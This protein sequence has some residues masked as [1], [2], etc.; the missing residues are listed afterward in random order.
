VAGLTFVNQVGA[1]EG[2]NQ[3]APGTL[4]PES[5]VRWSQDV[6][7]DRAGLMRRRGPFNK[8]KMLNNDTT[9]N[10]DGL[11]TYAIS[12]V[13]DERVLSVLSTYDPTGDERIGMLVDSYNKTS[14]TRETL[15]RVFDKTFRFLGYEK[16]PFVV[17]PLS[18]VSHKPA[19]GGGLWVSIC[20]DPSDADTHYQ[21]F[22]RGGYSSTR[23]GAGTFS[24]VTGTFT[25]E[26]VTNLSVE[27]KGL[28]DDITISSTTNVSKG[29]FVYATTSSND[30]Y[31]GTIKEINASIIT[32]DKRPFL[33]D[34]NTDNNHSV[35][36][37][38]A[39]ATS[40]T[41]VVTVTLSS[42]VVF[43]VGDV[44]YLTSASN[45]NYNNLT[46]T[47]TAVPP[48]TATNTF[49]F[50]T[51]FNRGTASDITVHM[52]N[53]LI[54][55]DRTDIP[56]K[57]VSV[58]PYVHVHGRGLLTINDG[59]TTDVISGDAGS[60]AE[61]HWQAASVKDYNV[62][63][64]SDNLYLGKVKTITN[65]NTLD[66][67]S[68]S[69]IKL[70]GEEYVMRSTDPTN[71]ITDYCVGSSD[72]NIMNFAGLYTA[73]YAGYQWYGN[74]GQDD[75]NTNRVVFSAPHDRE[76]VD[77]SR[78]AADSIIFP[79][80]SSFRG[81]GSS[82]AGLLV[83]LEDRT[84]IL[85]GNDRTNFSVEQ[86]VPEGCLCASSIVEYGGGVFWAGK[87]GIMF[88]DG[89]SVRNLTKDNLGLY[90]TDSL[91]V[92]NP[93]QDRVLGFMHKNN[94]IMH[95]TSWNSPFDPVR[96]EPIYADA[97][98]TT[99]GLK[100][101]DGNKRP[102][103]EF[104]PDFDYDDFF[105][106][107]NTPIF[108]DRKIL[109]NPEESST[110]GVGFTWQGA[111]TTYTV[112]N[113][114]LTSNVATLTIAAHPFLVNDKIWVSG[115]DSTFN[116]Q[117]TVTGITSTTVSY[118]KVASNVISQAATGTISK[119]RITWE[120]TI[121]PY[122]WG[123]LRSYTSLTFAIY[124]PTNAL[125]TLSNLDLRGVTNIE[126]LYGLK[127]IVGVNSVENISGTNRLRARLIDIHPVF[128]TNTNGEDDLL[129]EKINIPDTDIVKGPD[130]YLQTKHFTVGDPI[131]RK[132]FQRIML[133][134]L[135]Y[136]GAIRMDLV[137]D[138]DNDSV[139]INKK[140]HKYWEIFTEKG[141]DWTYLTDIQLPKLVSPN[142]ASWENVE[143]TV[144]YWDELFTADFNRYSK[145]I[146]WRKASVGFRLYQ[147]NNYK[148]PYNGVVTR[149]YRVEMQGFSI[150]FKP[151]RQ[152]RI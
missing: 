87:S 49:T 33:W 89:S 85:R 31:I 1:V 116:G 152:G 122:K 13:T 66:L 136:D 148:K 63:R 134:M 117:Y 41:S 123:P 73:I 11:F 119:S 151:L 118:A 68:D 142:R 38:N 106:E 71:L 93:S 30:Y 27:H 10:T 24:S 98:D 25:N 53:D 14:N 139:D 96:Y 23:T 150:G 44:V 79:G 32:L 22:W 15:L 91:D 111:P 57:F 7:F 88:F 97:W 40:S 77:L 58:R 135:L 9:T 50:S 16:L 59:D 84:Y 109:N 146:S 127:T 103:D 141:Y 110:T 115:V 121:N 102:W 128:D 19:L 62:Y 140:K 8:F 45:A 112:T 99:D 18:I 46:A 54:H 113:K 144:T 81:L 47:I 74:F 65:N 51:T 120:A 82:S 29:Q 5:F 137:D 80:K 75:E 37:T 83:F 39:A 101:A 48:T 17:T 94:L 70:E 42:A 92:F 131:L 138:D 36:F 125:T 126:T 35:V 64:S 107:N 95:Y 132:W 78:D 76:A 145:R 67:W 60:S 130:F 26:A 133:S 20:D 56:L 114:V 3:A 34:P 2:M 4:I 104:D 105:T 86:L 69:G 129:V 124:T 43:E 108:W 149:P 52:N 147:L 55:L 6:L 100:G 143:N 90:Y 21:F 61:G 72:N 28:S 12:G